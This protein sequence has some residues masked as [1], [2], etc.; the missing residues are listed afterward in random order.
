MQRTLPRSIFQSL[1]IS[2]TTKVRMSSKVDSSLNSAGLKPDQ[3]KAL[4]E[5][6][7][8]P[9]EGPI[10]A[11]IKELYSCKP[12]SNTFNIYAREAVFHDPVGIAKGID[13]VR[14][15]FF[16]LAKIFPRADIPKFRILETPPTLPSNT[17]LIDQ[18]VAYYR[19]AKST[20]PTKVV[21]SLLTLKLDN[22]NKVISHNEEWNHQKTTTGEDGFLGMINEQRKKLTAGLTDVF[23]GGGSKGKN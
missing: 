11:A 9:Q 6:K 14:S 13:S 10:I 16:G 3:T 2:K 19:D 15:Q 21:N 18:D 1:N 23:V 5:R 8:L 22:F 17:I 7:M 12:T 20:S 4:S